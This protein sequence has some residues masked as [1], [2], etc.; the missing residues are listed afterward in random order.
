MAE[1]R[2][3]KESGAVTQAPTN[4]VHNAF[5]YKKDASGSVVGWFCDWSGTFHPITIAKL[6]GSVTNMVNQPTTLSGYVIT[7]AYT[8]N[9]VDN[10]T[11]VYGN[12][13]TN[14]TNN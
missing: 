10:N 2:F 9:E 11:G 8:I 3:Y 6:D 7:E 12:L 14:N 1:L 5:V 13:N 4:G